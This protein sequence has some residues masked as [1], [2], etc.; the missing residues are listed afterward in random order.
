MDDVEAHVA[1]PRDPADRVQVRAVVVH[2]RAG[3]VE[4][5]GDLLDVLVEE[6]ERRGVGQHQAGGVLVDLAAQVLDVDVPAR[7]GLHR[8]ELV[9]GHRHA[10]RVRAVRGVGDDDLAPLL[11]LAA[12][13][14]V[15]A[16][17]QQSGQLALRAGGRL[18]RDGVEP[19]DLGQHLLQL[20]AE[21]QRALGAVLLLVRVEVAEARQRGE[22]LVDPRVVLHRAGAERVEAGVDPEVARRELG[23]VPHQVRLGE[24][25]QARR[26]GARELG[27]HLG[28][29]AGRAAAAGRRGG[30]DATS[31]RSASRREHL[32]QPVDLLR[33][34]LLGQRDEQ[35]V[36]QARVVAAERRSRD[37][38]LARGRRGRP[39]APAARR[40]PRTP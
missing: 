16:H 31:R 33:R 40:A 32:R 27:G 9:A 21:A 29:P 6:P 13:G 5:R 20:P 10:R 24:L 25:G 3:A 22:A 15:G 11:A 34:P 7:V 4:D 18:Q 14:E 39:P 12:L 1:G 36:V 19:G 26:L 38:R 23:E 8:R 37:G 28:G 30:P 17:Q 2:E 35:H